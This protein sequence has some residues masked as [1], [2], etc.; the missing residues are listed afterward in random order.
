MSD[1]LRDIKIRQ[2]KAREEAAISGTNIHDASVLA[3]EEAVLGDLRKKGL[4]DTVD[5][6][7]EQQ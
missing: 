7:D 1:L 2:L 3:G 4:L 5:S 6:P